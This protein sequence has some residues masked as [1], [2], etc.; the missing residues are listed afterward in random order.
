[1]ILEWGKKQNSKTPLRTY[2]A[3][4]TLKKNLELPRKVQ[5]G[6]IQ[7]HRYSTGRR[8]SLRNSR[9][10]ESKHKNKNISGSIAA[11]GKKSEI[12]QVS[13]NSRI[14]IDK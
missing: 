7:P 3:T 2:P 10:Y 11:I 5:R 12:I 1:M 13:I 8:I 9:T 4:T 6:H 14:R